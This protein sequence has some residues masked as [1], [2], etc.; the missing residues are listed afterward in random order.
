[1]PTL[2]S[3]DIENIH[4]KSLDILA[5]VGTDYQTPKALDILKKGGCVVDYETTQAM[6]PPDLVEW[7]L[8]Q[9]PRIVRLGARDPKRDVM[10][11]GSKS[12][13]TTDSQGT[14]AIDLETGEQHISTLA[15]LNRGLLFADAMEMLDIV[16]IM[17]AAQD[18]PAH[19]RTIR[20]FAQGFAQTS[21]HVRTGVLHPRQ[22]PFLIELVKAATGEDEFRPIFSVVD[23]TISPLLHD[24]PMT[25]A[26]IELA[27]LNV[28]IMIYPMPLAGGTSPV[29]QAGTL[30][31]NN[32]EFLSAFVLF[33]LT[34]PG[35]PIIYGV[36]SSQMDMQTGKY[37]GSADAQTGRIASAELAR[38]Y[39]LPFNLPGLPTHAYAID[40]SYGFEGMRDYVLALLVGADEIY[41]MGLL[42]TDQIL[43]LDKMVL[44]NHFAQ[45]MAITLEPIPLD[46][47]HLQADLIEKVGIG[48]NFLGEPVT[49]NFTHNEYIPVWPPPDQNLMDIIHE[50]A[51]DILQT[52]TPPPLPQSAPSKIEAIVEKANK[53]LAT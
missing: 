19:V 18:I 53:E 5:R 45:Q 4:A 35:A 32:V 42:G 6:I 51:L 13:H 17:V 2:T 49:R 34:N 44:D 11:D 38:H 8:E 47:E 1:M 3:Q 26:C 50:Q 24:G 37:G 20:H 30:L 15:D 31:I 16:N 52:H 14:Q 9:A 48:G 29:T 10:L 22:V 33:Q 40:I 43:S 28:P 23:C 21:K 27:R 41:S 7:A 36:G 12:H 39:N 25:E 46:D